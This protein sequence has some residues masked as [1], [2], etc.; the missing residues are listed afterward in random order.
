MSSE[1]CFL[2]VCTKEIEFYLRVKLKTNIHK[3]MNALLSKSGFFLYSCKLNYVVC[4]DALVFPQ[5]TVLSHAH[6]KYQKRSNIPNIRYL[7]K[8]PYMNIFDLPKY[9]ICMF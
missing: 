1:F 4:K 2:K 3:S 9:F 6:K 5:V 7:P 8:N